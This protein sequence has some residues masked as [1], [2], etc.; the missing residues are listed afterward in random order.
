MVRRP[1]STCAPERYD[2][3]ARAFDTTEC[4]SDHRMIIK[5]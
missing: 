3:D 1:R 4:V 2:I 5:Q